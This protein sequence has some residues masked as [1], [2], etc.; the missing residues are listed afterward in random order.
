MLNFENFDEL[1][2]WVKENRMA[3]IE[4]LTIDLSIARSEQELSVSGLFIYASEATDTTA[5][6][7]IRH[8]EQESGLITI[9]KNFGPVFPFYRL[10]LTNA[11]QAGKTITLIIGRAAPFDIK[12]NRS[13]T[14]TLTTLEQ[15]RDDQRSTTGTINAEATIGDVAE[16]TLLAVNPNR[17][18]LSV[19]ANPANTGYIYIFYVTAGG[20][21]KYKAILQAGQ[22]FSDD[23]YRGAVFAIASAAGQL[24]CAQ[25][26]T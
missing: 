12:D 19:Q 5:N 8:N 9:T 21:T 4:T 11:A 20:A 23:K 7:Q 2:K 18:S 3:S 10:F 13:Q 24:A 17:R 14:D 22:Y 16:E 1:L 15:I 26:E 6:L 25:E